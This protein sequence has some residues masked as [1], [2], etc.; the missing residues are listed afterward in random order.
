MLRTSPKLFVPYLKDMK[1]RFTGN[2]YITATGLRMMTNEGPAAVQ[3][4]ID[5]LE[6]HSETLGALKWKPELAKAAELLATTQGPTGQTGHTGPDGS[7][8]VS[9]I[10]KFMTWEKTIGENVI[11][12]VM[13]PLEAVLGWAIDDGVSS[14]GHRNNIMKK[15]FSWTGSATAMHKT[16]DSETV[17]CFSGAWNPTIYEAPKIAVPKTADEYKQ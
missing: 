2:M 17:A 11:Y 5:Y 6:G 8:M 10:N 13:T 7:T 12:R 16:Y 4:L 15:D 9:R 14:R 3:E 1:A